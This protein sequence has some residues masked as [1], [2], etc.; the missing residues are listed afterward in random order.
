[1]PPP[2]VQIEVLV[3]MLSKL[4]RVVQSLDGNVHNGMTIPID[5]DIGS[6]DVVQS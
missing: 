6:L 3:A 4:I 5:L 1:M 2:I